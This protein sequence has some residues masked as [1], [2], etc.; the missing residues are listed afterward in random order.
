MQD[1]NQ[2]PHP[3]RGKPSEI[4][5]CFSSE[6]PKLTFKNALDHLIQNWRQELVGS[7]SERP[8]NRRGHPWGTR[9]D[10][11]LGFPQGSACLRNWFGS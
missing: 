1:S 10:F 3:D 5:T 2:L 8:A 4:S 11:L 6:K 9:R 7:L